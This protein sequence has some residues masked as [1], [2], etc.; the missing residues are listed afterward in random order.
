MDDSR[1]V[2][3][4][5]FLSYVL[6]HH[7]EAIGISLDDG[8]W[9]QVDELLA[10]A[11]R[12][13]RI[14]RREEL[15]EVVERDPKRRFSLSDDR[16]RVR[17]NYGHSI[18]I[19]LGLEPVEPPEILFHGTDE[20]NVESI[21]KRGLSPKGRRFVHLS[22]DAHAAREVGSRHGEAAVLRIEARRMHETGHDFYQTEAGVWLTV[23]VP[24][25]YLRRPAAHPN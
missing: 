1:R 23:H 14:I 9:A 19:D 5:K 20:R 3:L 2:Q 16:R 10:G 24:A 11:K 13:G 4:S 7:P 17:A 25:E 8:G 15:I 18:P 12:I 21:L 6:R 22:T